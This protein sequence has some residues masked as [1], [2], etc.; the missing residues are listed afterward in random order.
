MPTV[1]ART[2]R[3]V[4]ILELAVDCVTISP[5]PRLLL[6]DLVILLLANMII[7]NMMAGSTGSAKEAE[8]WADQF[9]EPSLDIHTR[10]PH[11][12]SEG[13]EWMGALLRDAVL[14]PP[15]LI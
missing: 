9:A 5:S 11:G 10:D 15:T 14:T 1:P 3:V 7:G 6:R 4:L 12:G 13:G 2:L 8:A